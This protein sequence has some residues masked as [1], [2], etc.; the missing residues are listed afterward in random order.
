MRRISI[1]AMLMVFGGAPAWAANDYV[2][3]E[4]NGQRERVRGLDRELTA[5][6]AL[7]QQVAAMFGVSMRKFDLKVGGRKLRE[8]KT[9]KGDN[10]ANGRTL[11]I[12]ETNY[13]NQCT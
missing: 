11:T 7:K 13:S 5:V 9:L 8:G 6:C 12:V 4:F 2:F 10:I 3:V 1:A